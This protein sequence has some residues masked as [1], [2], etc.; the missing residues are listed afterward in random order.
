LESL[1]GGAV[2][3]HLD[4][5]SVPVFRLVVC[6]SSGGHASECRSDSTIESSSE[7]H[8]EGFR[9]GVSGISHEI[10]ELIQVVVDRSSALEV[11]VPFQD[12]DRGCLG[13]QGEEIFPKLV[14]EVVPIGKT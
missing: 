8:D 1:F 14:F 5:E 2:L 13:V 10:A 12:V 3:V 4:S 7:L 9:V 11:G 6:W